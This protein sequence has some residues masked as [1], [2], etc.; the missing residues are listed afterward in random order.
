LYEKD[1]NN[2]QNILDYNNT[3]NIFIA[4]KRLQ[5]FNLNRYININH[6]NILNLN[7]DNVHDVEI[8]NFFK[9]YQIYKKSSD[10]QKAINLLP[11]NI[12]GFIAYQWYRN[13]KS[14]PT[15]LKIDECEE[16]IKNL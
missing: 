8:K 15:E 7:F 16:I 11:T 12:L 1:F 14:F 4:T 13:K 6:K 9:S 5:K 10:L 3:S 2:V